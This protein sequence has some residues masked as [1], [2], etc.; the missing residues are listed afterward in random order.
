MSIASTP[1]NLDRADSHRF[2]QRMAWLC[3]TIA[4]IG[5]LPTYW[6]PMWSSTLQIPRIA[7]F[8]GMVFFAWTLFFVVQTSLVA[9][10]RTSMH[11]ELGLLGIALATSMLFTGTMVALNS[12][13]A[14]IARGFAEDARAFA[15][16]PLS[17]IAYFAIVVAYAIAHTK[18]PA[19]HKRA[20]VLA[21][22]ALLQP[23]VAR[24]FVFFLAPAGAQSPVPVIFTVVPGFVADL[25]LVYA[26][27]HDWRTRGSPHRIYVIGFVTILAMQVLRVPLGS[28]GAWQSIAEWLSAAPG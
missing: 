9:N 28:S 13:N 16:V 23:A 3:A 22:V 10:G 15:L 8:H 6:A 25:P 12:M 18:T 7:H 26:M 4:F 27:I 21:T 17:G 2:Y 14:F 20:M 24:W 11:R 5:F 19:L 1:A